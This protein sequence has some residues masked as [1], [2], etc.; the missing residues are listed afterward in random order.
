L[1]FDSDK[2]LHVLISMWLSS[3]CIL[4]TDVIL[5]SGLL[6]YY[7]F[8]GIHGLRCIHFVINQSF[9]SGLLCGEQFFLATHRL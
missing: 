1:V 6:V 2:Q 9:L 7:T 4:N 5:Q 8:L 3:D